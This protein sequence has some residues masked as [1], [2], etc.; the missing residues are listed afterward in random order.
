MKIFLS[1]KV[2]R[3]DAKIESIILHLKNVIRSAGHIPFVATDEIARAGLTNPA[4]FMPFVRTHLAEMDL[5]LLVYHPE[6]RGGLIE[7][8]IAYER[9]IP[10]WVCHQV[11]EKV[12]SSL[13]GCAE[14]TIE[15]KN[16][17]GLGEKVLKMLA[18]KKNLP[19]ENRI[20]FYNHSK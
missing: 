19:L 20:N 4:E 12:S 15:Y 7:A 2:P 5:F 13:L 1:L 10:I 14:E 3:G 9:E 18:E 6:L 11:G 16:V 8:G 17:R